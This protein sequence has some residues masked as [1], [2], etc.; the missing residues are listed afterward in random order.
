MFLYIIKTKVWEKQYYAC[1]P[2]FYNTDLEQ[3]LFFLALFKLI[4]LQ[5]FTILQDKLRSL[6]IQ[7]DRSARFLWAKDYRI[8]H[9]IKRFHEENFP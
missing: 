5:F 7:D 8:D 6:N 9:I 4:I 1:V 3:D 2:V